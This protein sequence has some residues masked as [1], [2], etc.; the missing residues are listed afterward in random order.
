MNTNESNSQASLHTSCK[1]DLVEGVLAA[2]KIYEDGTKVKC[3][4]EKNIITLS[5]K[6]RMLGIIYQ[7]TPIVIDPITTLHVGTGGSIDPLGFY[8]KLPSQNMTALY[9][10]LLTVNVS[11]TADT[12]VPSVTFIADI[13][14]GT[15]NGSLI[16]EAALYTSLGNMFNIKTFPGIP[17]T[18][19][20]SLHLEWTIKLA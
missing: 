14:Q 17:K 15:G 6:Q 20:F 8:P 2:Y 12:T 9:T 16:T 11:Y 5:A 3:F 4:E 18:S 19:E 10:D 7:S 1:A 13:D